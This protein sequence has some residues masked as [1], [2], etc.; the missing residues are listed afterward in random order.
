[1]AACLA[2]RHRGVVAA[3]L[4]IGTVNLCSLLLA[5][6]RQSAVRDHT[7]PGAVPEPR[8]HLDIAAQLTDP[9]RD[10]ASQS[11]PVGAS[12]VEPAAVIA[13]DNLNTVAGVLC[14]HNHRSRG[15]MT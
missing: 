7:D 15:R 3:A 4:T 11:E 13:H 1:M 10:R 12:R 14:P 8:P 9:L 5:G 6:R 2:P